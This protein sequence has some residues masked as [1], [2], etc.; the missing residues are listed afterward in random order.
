MPADFCN[1]ARF[2]LRILKGDICALSHCAALCGPASDHNWSFV[3]C[4]VPTKFPKGVL[5]HKFL[6]QP[7]VLEK[8]NGFQ[9]QNLRHVVRLFLLKIDFE[10]VNGVVPRAWTDLGPL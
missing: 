3:S 10:K 2:I 9:V 8:G 1:T 7:P 4:D 6:F 5:A